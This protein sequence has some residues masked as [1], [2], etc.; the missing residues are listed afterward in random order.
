MVSSFLILL[1]A[2][3]LDIKYREVDSRLWRT[4]LGFGILFILVDFSQSNNRNLLLLFIFI[5]VVA[6][7]FSSAIY[8]LGLMGGGDAKLLT[9]L[10]AMF[11]FLP[12]GSFLLPTFFLSV[13]TNAILLAILVNLWLFASNIGHLGGV[14]SLKE[15]F[16][17]FVARRKDANQVGRFEAVLEE[18]KFFIDM[19]KAEFGGSGREGEVWAVP[20][21]P[22]VVFMTIGFLISFAYG[23]VIAIIL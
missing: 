6:F 2:S 1:Y 11:P 3:I 7:V 22:F 21:L 18:G 16:R 17:L 14:H 15:L 4:M 19:G 13:F 23:D 9:A 12:M 20:A 8:Y 10:G 5:T